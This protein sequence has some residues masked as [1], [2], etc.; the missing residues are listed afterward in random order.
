[1]NGDGSN[2]RQ[3]TQDN[4]LNPTVSP[5]GRYVV[6]SSLKPGM[7]DIWRMDID[8]GNPKQL[9]TD[10][11][12]FT[13]VSPDGRWVIYS[14]TVSG[15]VSIW[16]V[17]IDGGDPVRLTEYFSGLGVVSPDGKSIAGL[18]REQTGS[19]GELPSFRLKAASRQSC[20]ISQ[21]TTRFPRVLI[22]CPMAGRSRT[23]SPAMAS[24]IFGVCRS[25]A[26]HQNS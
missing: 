20:S 19:R 22:G 4:S 23:S 7:T 17:S 2:P 15:V 11:G 12:G 26:V 10:Q 18:Y 8:G 24:Q 16:K 3:L 13:S 6:F 14:K 25:R 1:M 21:L 9:T 5:D